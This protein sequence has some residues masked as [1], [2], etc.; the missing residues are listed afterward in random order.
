M[1]SLTGPT[2]ALRYGVNDNGNA[3]DHY[4]ITYDAY[5]DGD[6]NTDV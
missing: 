6:G 4:T 5:G 3:Q 1:T 2:L